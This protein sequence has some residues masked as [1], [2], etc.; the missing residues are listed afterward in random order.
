MN[1]FMANWQYVQLE[2]RYCESC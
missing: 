2:Q 1:S